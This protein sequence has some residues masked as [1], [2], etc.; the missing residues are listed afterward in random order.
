MADQNTLTLLSAEEL[1]RMI[2]DGADPVLID[3]RTPAE[4]RSAH[5]L[6]SLLVPDELVSREAQRLADA[7]AAVD[8][9]VV[10]LCQAGPR[11]QQAQ[12]AL[13]AAGLTD[14]RVLSG[15][16]NAYRATV[17]DDAVEVGEGPWAMERQVRMAAGSLVLAGLLGGRL[18]SPKARVVSGA[19]ASGLVFSA[20][21]NTCGMAKALARMPWNQSPQGPVRIEDVLQ[22]IEAVGAPA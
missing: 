14:S 21:T 19:I 20:A 18:L 4:H 10:L 17:G 11:S 13:S 5:L 8:R 3:V 6:G 15:G 2:D 7:L 16:L 22:E 1:R 9:P 12:Q